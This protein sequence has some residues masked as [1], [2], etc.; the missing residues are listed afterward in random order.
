[1]R[2]RWIIEFSTI[3]HSIIQSGYEDV[4]TDICKTYSLYNQISSS[5]NKQKRCSDFYYFWQ[6]LT[7]KYVLV[8]GW[9]LLTPWPGSTAP[10]KTVFQPWVRK[11]F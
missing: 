10:A 8:N 2:N 5:E 3:Q 4:I 7:L 11:K 9:N 1:M 6:V